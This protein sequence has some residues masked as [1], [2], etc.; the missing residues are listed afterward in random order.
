MSTR[1]E[2]LT[3]ASDNID[4]TLRT[5]LDI[6]MQSSATDIEKAKILQAQRLYSAAT[7]T[8]IRVHLGL[9]EIAQ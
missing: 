8:Y 9:K 7:R 2:R 6:V 4:I 5:F 3:A 1:T